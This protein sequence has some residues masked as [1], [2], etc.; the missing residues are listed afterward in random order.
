MTYMPIT[1]KHDTR[2]TI[3]FVDPA[4]QDGYAPEDL[5]AR[6]LGG[7]EATILK[8]SVALREDFEIIHFQNGREQANSSPA[9][10]LR[11]LND[12]GEMIDPRAIIVIN[13]WKVAIK[14]RKQF[15]L[16][17]IFLWLHIHPGK[18]NRKMGA[19]LRDANITVICVSGSHAK[20]FREFLGESTP[21]EIDFI[22]NPIPDGLQADDTRRDLNRLIF[23]S[24]PHKGLRQ[25]YAQF[26]AVRKYLPNLVLAVADPGYLSWDS[27][28]PPANVLHLGVIPQERLL[29]HMRR[30]LC[31][32]YPQTS[33]AETFGLVIVEANAVGTPVLVQ[34]GLGANDEV[35][36]DHQQTVDGTDIEGL[37]GRISSWQKSFPTISARQEF[38]MSSVSHS[39]TRTLLTAMGIPDGHSRFAAFS[40]RKIC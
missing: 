24:A 6:A 16:T 13:S 35:A 27:G 21:P 12:I 8:V 23:A 39:W 22:Y 2:P 14:L 25:I 9:G 5:Y 7:T 38:R 40:S 17:P 15:E 3:A 11:P 36:P 31:L 10:A 26:D 37:V 1:R 34:K 30:S 32:F 4:C 20:Q 18:H 28:P 19:A 33:F 29:K